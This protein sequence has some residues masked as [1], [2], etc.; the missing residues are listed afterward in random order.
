MINKSGRHIGPEDNRRHHINKLYQFP[1][2]K[3]LKEHIQSI[4]T[5]VLQPRQLMQIIP[6]QG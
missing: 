6:L 2:S 3:F 4:L 1:F 5:S